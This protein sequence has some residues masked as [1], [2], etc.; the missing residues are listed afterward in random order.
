M[1]RDN[2]LQQMEAVVAETMKSF[3]SDFYDYDK[4]RIESGKLKFPAIWIVGESHTYCL[5]LGNY[6]DL[7]YECESVRYN[8]LYDHNPYSHYTSSYCSNDKWFLIT[9][10]GLQPIN[11]KQA[12]A[13]IKDYVNP[14]VQAW[15]AENG[16]LPK[17]TKVPVVLKNITIAELKALVAECRT[18]DDDS[19]MS[20]LTRF[21]Q[22]SRVA[23]N[24]YV[25]VTYHKQW[26]E[27]QF[28]EYI[29]GERRLVGGIVFHGWPETGYQTNGSVQ[30]TQ[31]YGWASHT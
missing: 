22:Y 4:P 20:C 30:L 13:A 18:H 9:E 19:L 27:F 8:Y 21:H 15:I 25:E 16:P 2:I 6:K 7:F 26:R 31:R 14:A 1:N 5:E 3:Q 11:C 28:C 23:A 17:L 24:Q 10:A 12:E 29:N